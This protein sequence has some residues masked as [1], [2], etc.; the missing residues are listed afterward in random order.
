MVAGHMALL[1]AYT[2]PSSWVPIRL[3]YWSQ[4]YTRVMFHQDWRLFAPD[5]P[6][7]GC[8]V[9]VKGVEDAEWVNLHQVHSH[10]VWERMCSNACRYAEVGLAANDTTV[11]APIALTR[12]LEAMT[13]GV[14]RTGRL[15]VRLLRD[16]GVPRNVAVELTAH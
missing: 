7:C 3:R 12:S 4:A 13:E 9:Q 16:G 1:A 10:F 15:Q 2:L 11:T 5:P 14:P 6:M 8:A